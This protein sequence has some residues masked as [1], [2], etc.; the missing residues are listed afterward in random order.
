MSQPQPRTGLTCSLIP[1]SGRPPVESV[2]YA[3]ALSI[4]MPNIIASGWSHIKLKPTSTP[5]YKLDDSEP[6]PK[7]IPLCSQPGPDNFTNTLKSA[8]LPFRCASNIIWRS[9]SMRGFMCITCCS[10]A[11]GGLRGLCSVSFGDMFL[12][13]YVRSNWKFSPAE[14]EYPYGAGLYA[15]PQ[16]N[17]EGLPLSEIV[18]RD[19]S[20]TL[21]PNSG[22]LSTPLEKFSLAVL[23]FTYLSHGVNAVRD[24]FCV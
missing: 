15:Y 14:G 20:A 1:R 19:K 17:H 3:M 24:F 6:P 18:K 11:C 7:V 8:P 22:T 13:S 10:L 21:L 9:F 16:G 5:R 2:T 23:E 12:F 4:M